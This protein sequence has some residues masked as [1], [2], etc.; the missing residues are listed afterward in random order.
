MNDSTRYLVKHRFIFGG[1]NLVGARFTHVIEL[2]L[3]V[4]HTKKMAAAMAKLTARYF[5][6]SCELAKSNFSLKPFC[7]AYLIL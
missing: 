4:L 6:I 5:L 3:A 7:D 2:A 1:K